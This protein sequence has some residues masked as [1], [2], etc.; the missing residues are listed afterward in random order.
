MGGDKAAG[1]LAVAGFG[2][3]AQIV[4]GLQKPAN[5][6]PDHG[7]IIGQKDGYRRAHIDR[8]GSDKWP[9][10]QVDVGFGMSASL[11]RA[12]RE[13]RHLALWKGEVKTY[14]VGRTRGMGWPAASRTVGH[15]FIDTKPMTYR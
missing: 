11:S 10:G 15:L 13:I 3:D 9:G 1:V 4:G 2:H 14:H 12:C 6:G 5:T 7:M 8:K